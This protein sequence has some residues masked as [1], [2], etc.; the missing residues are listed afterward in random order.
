MQNFIKTWHHEEYY[1]TAI[2]ALDEVSSLLPSLE[3]FASDSYV[4]STIQSAKERVQKAEANLPLAKA[5]FEAKP[6]QEM[7]SKSADKL[8][9]FIKTWQH[10]EYYNKAMEGLNEL[11]AL[12]PVLENYASDS[13]V[14]TTLKVAKDRI[15]AVQSLVPQAKRKY[16]AEPLRQKLGQTSAKLDVRIMALSSAMLPSNAPRYLSTEFHKVVAS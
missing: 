16:E 7:V 14:A 5:R 13:G 3:A 1:N 8:S 6:L 12:L 15:A 2:E 4:A 9:D 10:E 11:E